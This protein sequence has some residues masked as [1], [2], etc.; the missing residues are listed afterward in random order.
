MGGFEGLD[1]LAGSPHGIEV[2]IAGRRGADTIATRVAAR[3]PTR[4]QDVL[5]FV[6]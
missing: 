1:K 4:G 2:K 5:G 6:Q 3:L